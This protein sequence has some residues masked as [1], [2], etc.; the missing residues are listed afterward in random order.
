M[1]KAW[2]KSMPVGGMFA[3][4]YLAPEPIGMFQIDV[5]VKGRYQGSRVSAAAR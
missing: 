2:L 4:T 5:G 3:A 1:R